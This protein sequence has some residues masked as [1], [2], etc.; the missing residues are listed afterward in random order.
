MI[1][2]QKKVC[3]LVNQHAT[4]QETL[5]IFQRI[6]ET[7]RGVIVSFL[8]IPEIPEG[9]PIEQPDQILQ[10]TDEPQNFSPEMDNEQEHSP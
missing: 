5:D 8:A 10:D 9:L 2:L 7:C 3:N 1:D 6:E 4:N